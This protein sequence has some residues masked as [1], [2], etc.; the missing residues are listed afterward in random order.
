MEADESRQKKYPLLQTI[1]GVKTVTASTLVADVPELG[2]L[3]H[4][5]IAKLVGVAPINRD[6]GKQRGQ[7]AIQ[8]G[9]ADVRAVL[10]MSALVAVRP[11]ATFQKIYQRLLERGKAKKVAIVAVMRRL[12][13]IRNAMIR[14]NKP[15]VDAQKLIAQKA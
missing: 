3:D 9:R 5:K 10:Y 4:K 7:R 15:F 11:N 6:S 13:K 12:L 14:D 2:K 1:K 8:G